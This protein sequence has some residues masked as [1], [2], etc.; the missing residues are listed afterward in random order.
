MLVSVRVKPNSKKPRIERAEDG[1][2]I[3]YLKSPPIEGKANQ[4]L[5]ARLAERFG[6]PKSRLRIKS[7][8][9]SKTKLIEVDQ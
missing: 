6:V 4:E 3:A 7:G 2:L 1:A 5:I 9:A 8:L